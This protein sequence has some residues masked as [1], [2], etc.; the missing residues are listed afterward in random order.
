LFDP[1][2]VAGLV[3]RCRAGRATGFLENQALVAV[4][5][6]QIWYGRFIGSAHEVSGLSLDDADVLLGD[7]IHAPVDSDVDR[8]TWTDR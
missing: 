2:A 8:H 3:R 7:S 1:P 4:L 5:S 6:A